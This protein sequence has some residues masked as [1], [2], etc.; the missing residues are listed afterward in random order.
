M[1]FTPESTIGTN[2]SILERFKTL[3]QE[4]SIQESSMQK[5]SNNL[6]SILLAIIRYIIIILILGFII[7]NILANLN[8]LQ[9]NVADFFKPIIIIFE[10][11][12]SKTNATDT[13]TEI[14]NTAI[15]NTDTSMNAVY[16]ANKQAVADKTANDIKGVPVDINKLSDQLPSAQPVDQLFRK[17]INKLEQVFE[18]QP[19]ET[20]SSRSQLKSGY[21]YIGTDR[22]YRSCVKVG[23]DDMCMS[24]D[25]FPSIDICI[26]PS[27]RP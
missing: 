23:A 1:D 2:N 5:P 25:I 21:C 26:N 16:V 6:F 20:G 9:P 7:I 15:Q 27:L 14:L 18:P 17:N 8:M 4:S 19:N 3:G 12:F 13:K 10:N 24:G 11:P 22:G